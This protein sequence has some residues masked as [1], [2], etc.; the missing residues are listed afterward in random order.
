M[1]V[2]DSYNVSQAVADARLSYCVLYEDGSSFPE[3]G[4]LEGSATDLAD[5]VR[6]VSVP[7]K[8]VDLAADTLQD[9]HAG[10]E[11]GG[12]AGDEEN[13]GLT[14]WRPGRDHMFSSIGL[15]VSRPQSL[16]LLLECGPGSIRI[17]GPKDIDETVLMGISRVKRYVAQRSFHIEQKK[18][19][20]PAR[21]K[22]TAKPPR[23]KRHNNP[24]PT[25]KP[26]VRHEAATET[27]REEKPS[28]ILQ[29]QVN[30][31]TQT[32][33]TLTRKVKK[34]PTKREEYD[35]ARNQTP[36]RKE[37]RRQHRRKLDKIA[38]ETS[39][40]VSCPN[41]AIKDQTRCENCA[42]NHRQSRRRSEE[43]KKA[44]DQAK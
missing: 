1:S 19:T 37:Y 41:L 40:C 20:T 42:E 33:S 35:R 39:K 4:W 12:R 2:R 21:T 43:K 8:E 14:R 29:E 16:S 27:Q 44:A 6:L 17:P 38:K 23:P 25:P 10:D 9:G 22:Q 7:Q 30:P 18:R 36:E 31:T 13:A 5:L 15:G 3:S 32:K 24:T 28:A 11:G 34:T 26:R